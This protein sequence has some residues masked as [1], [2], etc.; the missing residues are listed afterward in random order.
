MFGAAVLQVILDSS[1]PVISDMQLAVPPTA[2]RPAFQLLVTFSEP[3]NWLANTSASAAD[4]SATAGGDAAAVA[5]A[6]T[7]ST[8]PVTYSSSRLLLT[9]AALIN[10]SVVPGTMAVLADGQSSR[11]ASAFVLWF[12]SWSGAKTVVEIL[13]PAYQDLGGNRGDQ[14]TALQV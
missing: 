9:N 4:A 14:D 10:I 12:R 11:A 8:A 1:P 13:G 6:D 3:I 2:D 7:T 5:A